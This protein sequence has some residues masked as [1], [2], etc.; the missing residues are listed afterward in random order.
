MSHN[1]ITLSNFIGDFVFSH[2][3]N[4][5]MSYSHIDLA[6]ALPSISLCCAN[7]VMIK[8]GHVTDDVLHYRAHTLFA[9]YLVRVGMNEW[10]TFHNSMA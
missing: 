10:I 7:G 3:E 1:E 2:L 4:V 6:Y 5:S 8:I 9:W